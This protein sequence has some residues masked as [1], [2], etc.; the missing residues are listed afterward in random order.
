LTRCFAPR[1]ELLALGFAPALGSESR[2]FIIM[3]VIEFEQ[4]SALGLTPAL[5]NRAARAGAR[6]WQVAEM[7]RI[8]AVHRSTVGAH[9]GRA[10]RA[11]ARL[12]RSC[13]RC[14]KKDTRSRSAT[15]CSPRATRLARPGSKRGIFAVVAHR[16]A[17]QRR[18]AFIPSSATST[19][20]CW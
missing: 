1:A 16:A 4:L 9:D 5:A 8:T 6:R 2:E 7:L 12:P 17:R 18:P 11:R 19:P 3:L 15:G 10:E 14:R 20:R 13:A